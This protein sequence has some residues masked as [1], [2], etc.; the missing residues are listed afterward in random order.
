MCV[1]VYVCV[2]EQVNMLDAFN[3]KANA[4]YVKATT[5]ALTPLCAQMLQAARRRHELWQLSA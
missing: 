4:L 5:I 3:G 1:C 2:G